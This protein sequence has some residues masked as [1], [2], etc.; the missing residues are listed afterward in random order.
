MKTTPHGIRFGL[1]LAI[2]AALSACAIAPQKPPST[3]AVVIARP[4][5]P[6]PVIVPL[7]QVSHAPPWASLTASFV[8]HD[9]GSSPLIHAWEARYTRYPA[10]FE[11]LLQQS[12]PLML[13]VQ[14]QLQASG[15]PGEFIMLPMLESSYDSA[16]PSVHGNAAGM[17]QLMPRTAHLHGITVNRSY[18]GRLDP[19]ASTR[20]ALAMLTD[21]EKKFG[22]WRLADMAY[23]AGPYA[24]LGVLRDHPDL[25]GTPIPAIPM[26]TITRN[27]LAKLMALS[28]ILRDPERFHVKLPEPSPA[29]ELTA[30]EVP[31]GT[32][33]ADAA[34][35]AEISESQLRALNTGYLGARVPADSPRT[36]LLPG[37]AA[38]SLTTA[39]AVDASETVAQVSMPE[40]GTGNAR[41]GDP[42]LPTEPVAPEDVADPQPAATP[43]PDHAQRHHVHKGDTLWSLAHRYHVSVADLQRWNHLH[44]DTVHPGELLRVHG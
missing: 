1:T 18:D 40:P 15:I 20:V 35:M 3:P 38:Q 37:N 4:E 25:G 17:W 36:L 28:C 32:R 11:Q 21:F 22:D 12:L 24:V 14:K 19:V 26:N 13:Y 34:R 42:P 6:A 8:M 44:G 9:C 41:S 39:L 30:V 7:A 23:N 16:Q 43:T 31:A 27:H 5:P 29:D 10:G 2:A 33:L